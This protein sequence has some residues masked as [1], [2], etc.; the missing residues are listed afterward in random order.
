MQIWH[1]WIKRPCFMGETRVQGE[2]EQGT[3]QARLWGQDGGCLPSPCCEGEAVQCSQRALRG[4]SLS[5]SHQS[6]EWLME[7]EVL[8][9]TQNGLW[10]MARGASERPQDPDWGG[11]I[12]HRVQPCPHAPDIIPPSVRSQRLPSPK[13][14]FPGNHYPP[15]S[16]PR[17]GTISRST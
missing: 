4:G 11:P 16:V 2:A 12:Q 5:A 7:K 8:P 13:V 3:L 10:Q 17:S 1:L 9:R 14:S 15:H 6:Q